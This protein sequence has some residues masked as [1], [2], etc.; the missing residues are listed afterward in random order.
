LFFFLIAPHPLV[1]HVLLIIKASRSYSDTT[2]TVGLLWMSDQNIA[3]TPTCTTYNIFNRETSMSRVGF[4]PAIP[5]SERLQTH[6]LDRVAFET[7][8]LEFS[9]EFLYT[10]EDYVNL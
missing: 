8:V 3:E 7:D 2:H 4:E 6:A 1:G 9:V 10:F 5:T